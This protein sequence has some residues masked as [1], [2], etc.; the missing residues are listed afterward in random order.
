MYPMNIE[1]S[2]SCSREVGPSMLSV[3]FRRRLLSVLMIGALTGLGS[4]ALAQDD[5]EKEKDK[6]D[7]DAQASPEGQ[8]DP[9]KRPISQKQKKQNAKSLRHELNSNDKRW[10]NQDVVWIITDEER[11]AFMMLSNDEERENFIESF[12]QRRDPTPDTAENEFKEEHYRRIAYAN[13]H[14][15]AA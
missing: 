6:S 4:T 5:K 13:E 7:A 11:K 14:F 9:L 12:W 8:T 3:G 10:L 15:P 1:S 2:D